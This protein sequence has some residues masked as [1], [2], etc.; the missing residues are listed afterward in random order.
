VDADLSQFSFNVVTF[1][2]DP[3][4]DFITRVPA[5]LNSREL[6]FES[7]CRELQLPSYFGNNWDALSEC[8]RD[9][10]WIR[11]RR[12]VILHEDWPALDAK[13]IANYLD[14]LLCAVKFWKSDKSHEFIVA[15][16]ARLAPH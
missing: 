1:T 5:G 7:L 10:H 3:E 16:P 14:I 9:F 2:L 4:E 6:L 8:V 12:V 13:A 15:F 11:N